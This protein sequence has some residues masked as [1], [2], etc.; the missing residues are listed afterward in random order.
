ME[1]R[2]I[3]LVA[4]TTYAISLPKEWVK[5]NNLKERNEVV[6]TEK[7]NQTLVITPEGTSEK[8]LQE[9]S[10][11]IEEHATNIDQILFAVYYLGIE[12]IKLFAKK[13]IPK[14]V[15]TRVMNTLRH[16]SGTEVSYEDRQKIIIRVLLDKHKVDI[17]QV[18][19]RISLLIDSSL[20]NMLNGL[21][22]TEIRLNEYEIDRLYH[23]STKI[24]STS[25]LDS[26]ILQSSQIQN[27]S[28]IPSFFLL[29]KRL[30]N[31][32]D[33][34]SYLAEYVYKKKS[35]LKKELLTEVKD[36]IERATKCILKKFTN[37]YSKIPDKR[38]H[39]LYEEVHQIL[40]RQV[41]EYCKEIIRLLIDINEE[42]VNISF[43][44]KLIS[45]NML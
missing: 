43:Y 40:D 28:L 25:L 45:E 35:S 38:G 26:S 30:E 33:N 19:Y 31:I 39:E 7:N 13:D 34:I 14:E 22:I 10:L 15:K 36:D 21:D 16:M 4:G 23:L 42:L 41:A 18:L 3:Q 37:I 12:E 44:N 29:S 5:K 6:V 2:K 1:R 17:I 27:I 32:A 9:V 24:I 8:K 11:N 20:A